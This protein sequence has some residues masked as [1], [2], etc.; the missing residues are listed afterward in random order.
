MLDKVIGWQFV[1]ND[2]S[3]RRDIVDAT[4]VA[5]DIAAAADAAGVFAAVDYA[6]WSDWSITR[7]CRKPAYA[8][9]I[10]CCV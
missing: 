10:L 2:V 6:Q 4:V 1:V 3:D 9:S 5:V 8:E 7:S